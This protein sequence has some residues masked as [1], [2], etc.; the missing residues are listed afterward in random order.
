MLMGTGR[1]RPSLTTRDEVLTSQKKLKYSGMVDE[2][3]PDEKVTLAVHPSY[4]QPPPCY[5]VT[6][7]MPATIAATPASR[8]AVIASRRNTH[9]MRHVNSGDE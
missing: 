3:C 6:I 7:T 1:N 2:G 5:R 8:S 4:T 9:A